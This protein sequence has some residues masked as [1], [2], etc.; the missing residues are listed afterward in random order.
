VRRFIIIDEDLNGCQF[1]L[2]SP[3]SNFALK[4]FK[5][6]FI[7]SISTILICVFVLVDSF[8]TDVILNPEIPDSFLSS[9]LL[10]VILVLSRNDE[11]LF[12]S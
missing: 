5:K 11:V 10:K 7:P 2:S 9:E 3:Q 1:L 12:I 4:R 6:G 8:S